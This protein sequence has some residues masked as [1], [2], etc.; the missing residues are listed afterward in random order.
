M[1]FE[2]EENEVDLYSKFEGLDIESLS[3]LDLGCGHNDSPVSN[4]VLALPFDSLTSVD[5]HR[6][7][8]NLLRGKLVAA[9]QHRIVESEIIA[10]VDG[11]Q[12]SDCCFDVTLLLDI[13]EHFTYNDA[14]KLLKGIEVITNKRVVIWIPLGVCTQEEYDSNPYQV[15]LSTWR[16]TNLEDLGYT[17]VQPSYHRPVAWAVRDL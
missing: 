8:L 12:R 10:Y 14:A 3:V 16:R 4:Q 2:E 6:P 13:L 17:V 9:R 15:H 7:Y 5:V 1:C 11:Q